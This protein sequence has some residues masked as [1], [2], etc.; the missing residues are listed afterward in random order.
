MHDLL[1][2][3]WTDRLVYSAQG[4]IFSNMLCVRYVLLMKGQEYP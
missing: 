2:K 1:R 4:R 3:T